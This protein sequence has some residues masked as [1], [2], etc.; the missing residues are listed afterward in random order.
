[1]DACLMT[2]I[3][4][5]YQL[6]DH[7]QILMGSE[8]IEPG[9][10]WPDAAILGDLAAKPTVGP[11]ELGAPS[12][13]AT[14]SPTRAPAWMPPS[15]P[16]I[17]TRSTTW[18]RRWMCP[19]AGAARGPPQ[20]WHGRCPPLGLAPHAALLRRRLRGSS[21]LR[22]GAGALDRS[23]ENPSRV[24]GPAT[25]HRGQSRAEPAVRRGAH[26]I[27]G[28]PR[29]R[30]LHPPPGIPKPG[31]PLP[32]DRLRPA[33][34]LGRRHGRLPWAGDMTIRFVERARGTSAVDGPSAAR[35]RAERGPTWGT[36]AAS[37]DS[38]APRPAGGPCLFFF[39]LT[40][41]KPSIYFPLDA[42]SL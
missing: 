30:A 38:A 40:S 22:H 25:G 13:A 36:P 16:S 35:R 8:E 42:S 32:R 29:A 12:S 3:E 4:V 14:S 1:M 27:A 19:R 41:E 23:P 7:A 10:G 24:R 5:A 39:R 6:R 15:P 21:P 9:A 17:S 20:G 26:R 11:E 37:L 34:P 33:H 18:W 2:M 31:L 28:R